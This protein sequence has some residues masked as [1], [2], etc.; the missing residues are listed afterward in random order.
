MIVWESMIGCSHSFL[1]GPIV[2]FGAR[3]VFLRGRVVNLKWRMLPR[4]V[5][6]HEFMKLVVAMDIC[7]LELAVFV[8]GH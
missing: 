2:S 3:N 5:S 6:V 1:Y 7:Y 8:D 4:G